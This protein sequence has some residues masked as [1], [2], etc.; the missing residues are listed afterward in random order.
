MNFK[1]QADIFIRGLRNRKRRSVAEATIVKYNSVLR[2][3]VLP[4]LGEKALADVG[5]GAL[6]TLIS[7]LS[8]A[9]VSAQILVVVA[10]VVK[11]VVASAT[12]ENG[13]PLHPRTW[14]MDFVDVPIIDPNTQK[15]PTVSAKIVSDTIS[16][17][18]GQERGLV[19]LLA[20]TGLRIGEAL[21]LFVGSADS[22][23]STWDHE[24]GTI[25]VR[26]T[27][28]GV[29]IQNNPKTMAGVRQVDLS[30][31]L[32]AFLVETLKPT[33]GNRVFK[34]Q[35]GGIYR[36]STAV[37]KLPSIPG[38]HSLRRF[39]VTHLRQSAAPEGLVKFWLG[40]AG[41]GTTDRY[42]KTRVDVQVRKL[43]AEKAGL[44]FT[45]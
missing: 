9:G 13:N 38:F 10:V 27:V 30:P 28:V 42:D 2:N 35:T 40:H 24:T 33:V 32:N 41:D 3:H 43:A 19:A 20:G 23:N 5:N 8:E 12:D 6:K 34:S 31:E 1:Q 44:G 16:A 15:A 29:T 21:A 11:L 36:R 7:Q 25:Y 18:Q 17:T 37:D 45:L 39:R 14:N 22:I 4:T 26:S